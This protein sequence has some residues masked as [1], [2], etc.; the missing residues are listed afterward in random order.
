MKK[1]IAVLLA[2]G[3]LLLPA[4]LSFPASAAASDGVVDMRGTRTY[5]GSTADWSRTWD[6]SNFEDVTGGSVS[7]NGN[8]TV[9][10]GTV[11]SVDVTGNLTISDGTVGDAGCSGSAAISGG[12]L[13]SVDAGGDVSIKG[14][15]VKHDVTS[16]GGDVTLNGTF[17][18]GGSVDAQTEV[19]FGGGKVTIAGSASGT[20]VSLNASAVAKI[21]GA[22]SVTGTLLLRDGT[23]TASKID[24]NDSA[25]IEING[26][27]GQIPALND[28]SDFKV[29]SGKKAILSQKLSLDALYLE[30]NSEFIDYNPLEVNSITGSGTLC[31]D[32][33][34]L[35]VHEAITGTPYLLFNNAVN[36]GDTAFRAD[37]GAVLEN[38]VQTYGYYFD[39]VSSGSS[40]LFRLEKAGSEGISIDQSS[41]TVASGS[42]GTLHASVSPNF[43]KYATG[44]QIIWQLNGDSSAFSISPD[45]DRTTCKVSVF[46]SG[47][48]RHKAILTAY[49]ADKGKTPLSDY[50]ADSCILSTGY[51]DQET[52]S[53]DTSYV[54]VLVGNTYGVLAA[55]DASVAPAAISYNSSVVEVT[56]TKAVKDKNG[57]P[58]WLY[59]VTGRGNGST[60][61]DIGGS[62]MAVT[63]NSGILMDTMSYTMAPKAS[64][65]AG[66]LARGV[67][68]K[69]IGVVS[70]SASAQVS[71]Y[72]KGSDGVILY[73]IT[74]V[75]EGSADI[76]F[77]VAG[78]QSVKMSVTVKAGAASSGKSAR[79]VAL[80][81]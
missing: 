16:D 69:S 7:W 54:S 8:L 66:V 72:K 43:S 63:V 6:A 36:S 52:V 14:G 62:Q 46:S 42:T 74:G 61:V 12:V 35:T 20:N 10:A 25:T 5:V 75:Q 80:K 13:K 34:E 76:V 56:G 21:S 26:F 57:N 73:R 45:S 29:D 23:L 22:V 3:L 55:T 18:I 15:S 44:T 79:L 81:Q 49:L 58:A 65:C 50:R 48:G 32:A 64:Y 59:T 9:K 19:L 67:D 30:D 41:L 53:L 39:A 71:F 2:L 37:Q 1:L 24:G 51:T 11:G 77:T 38:S 31:I 17:T 60:T 28:I 40:E 68:E 27:S 70:T 33:G 47:S 78:G 4:P